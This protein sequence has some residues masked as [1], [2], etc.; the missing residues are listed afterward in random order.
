MFHRFNR[1]GQQHW[2]TRPWPL[3]M[4]AGFVLLTAAVLYLSLT[5]PTPSNSA[6]ASPGMVTADPNRPA[7]TTAAGPSNAAPTTPGSSAQT[8]RTPPASSPTPAIPDSADQ[9]PDGSVCGLPAGDQTVPITPPA[10]DTWQLLGGQAVPYS[11][12]FGPAQVD[13]LGIGDCYAHSPTGAVFA[14]VGTVAALNL[15][16]EVSNPLEVMDRR[17][18]PVGEVY[19]EVRSQAERDVAASADRMPSD[20]ASA[21]PVALL[22]FTVTDYTPQRAIVTLAV[23]VGDPARP[24]NYL[25][26]MMPVAMSWHGGDWKLVYTAAMLSPQPVV[27][28]DQYVRWTP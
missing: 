8:F 12:T 21:V 27:S 2:I 23:S 16:I 20:D 22:G 3:T 14:A 26:A 15:P 6:D 25:Q 28:P 24:E 5:D 4:L 9:V 17:V 18:A 19:L 11:A 10:A 13:D 1:D 7:A